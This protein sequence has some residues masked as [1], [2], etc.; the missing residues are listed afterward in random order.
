L[1]STKST[2]SW[3]SE[4]SARDHRLWCESDR[5]QTAL[6][7]AKPIPTV[8]RQNKQQT[9][10]VSIKQDAAKSESK[11]RRKWLMASE[12]LGGAYHN[13]SGTETPKGWTPS[14]GWQPREVLSEM[15]APVR[16][17]PF[18]VSVHGTAQRRHGV[19]CNR[20]LRRRPC[21]TGFAFY[22]FYDLR[23]ESAGGAESPSG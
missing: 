9:R 23:V 7:T 22:R 13:S 14:S 1:G 10:L 16:C 6:K 8:P 15:R 3:H 17:P 12:P 18:R 19:L 5:K 2:P 11:G 4:S 21:R 20:E